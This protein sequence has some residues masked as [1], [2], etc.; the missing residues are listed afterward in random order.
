[1]FSLKIEAATT[2]KLKE[3]LEYFLKNGFPISTGP[4]ATAA[5]EAKAAEQ[6]APTPAQSADKPK[7]GRPAGATKVE[8]PVAG[9]TA[10]SPAAPAPGASAAAASGKTM[11]DVRNG[12]QAVADK[13]GVSVV[14]EILKKHGGPNGVSRIQEVKPEF[15]DAVI[16]ACNKAVA[17]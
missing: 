13:L 14:T 3:Q 7:R 1:M 16:G 2:E 8:A 9:P 4:A 6:P 12:C 11:D 5:H 10:P 15:Y 17:A